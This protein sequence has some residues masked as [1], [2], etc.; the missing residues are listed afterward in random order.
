MLLSRGILA[1]KK[2]I[3]PDVRSTTTIREQL[4]QHRDHAI[5]Q[6]CH[7]KIDP[8]G[9]A[10]ESFDVIGGYRTRYRSIG[11][12]DLAERGTI[13]P[14]IGGGLRTLLHALVASPLLAN[15]TPDDARARLSDQVRHRSEGLFSLKP[16]GDLPHDQLTHATFSI[17][18]LDCDACS[19]AV[20]DIL[21]QV[22]GV[23]HATASFGEGTATAWFDPNAVTAERLLTVLNERGVTVR[24]EAA[25]PD[26]TVD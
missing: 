22:E 15:A 24:Q 10:L 21:V 14:M 4:Q 23:A 26:A 7:Q 3:E 11:E 25:S 12:G 2:A 8:H 13:D 1:R 17:V 6:S 20:H 9:F 18:G 19:L 5:C 16:D